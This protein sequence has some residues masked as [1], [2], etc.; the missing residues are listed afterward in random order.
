VACRK[1]PGFTPS[2][3]LEQARRSSRYTDE[4]LSSLAFEGTAPVAPELS[5]RWRVVLEVAAEIISRLPVGQLGQAVV[6]PEGDLFKGGA[7]DL[8]RAFTD[9]RVAFHPGRIGG[10]WPRLKS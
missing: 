6:T 9:G 7:S 4:E 1:D 10:A 5:Q 8:A 2:G 3:I